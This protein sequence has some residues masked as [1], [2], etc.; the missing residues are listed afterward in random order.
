M[1]FYDVLLYA[2]CVRWTNVMQ[3]RFYSKTTGDFI[4]SIIFYR[5][6]G[7]KYLVS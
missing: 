7:V 5:N 3:T 1:L 4:G 6:I 2:V